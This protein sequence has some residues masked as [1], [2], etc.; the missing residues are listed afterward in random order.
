MTHLILARYKGDS[1]Y[2]ETPHGR[3]FDEVVDDICGDR[4][5]GQILDVI[6]LTCGNAQSVS[7]EAAEAIASRM[8]AEDFVC[9]EALD[10]ASSVLSED[11][12]IEAREIRG[13]SADDMELD[14]WRDHRD[15]IER[16]A[17]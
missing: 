3:T 15:D 1:Y 5:A 9:N 6:Y 11:L 14:D 8:R 16:V 13:E 7:Y 2:V 17:E 4:V 12:V 10:F